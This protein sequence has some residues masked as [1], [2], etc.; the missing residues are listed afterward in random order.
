MSTKQTI[1]SPFTKEYRVLVT[2]NGLSLFLEGV[3]AQISLTIQA[4]NFMQ[5]AD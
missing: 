2:Y 4:K 3:S 5:S 1:L